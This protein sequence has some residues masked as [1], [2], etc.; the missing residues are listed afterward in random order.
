MLGAVAQRLAS[1]LRGGDELARWG[2]DE[3][4]VLL[5][6]TSRAGAL[7]AASRL[8]AAVAEAPVAIPGG[9][10]AVTVSVGWAHWAGDTADDLLARAD[11]ALYKAKDAGRNAI[12]PPEEPSPQG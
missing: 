11:R 10:V 6:D 1:A 3:F 5:P 9:E 12:H 8:R 4:V 7:R 2:G